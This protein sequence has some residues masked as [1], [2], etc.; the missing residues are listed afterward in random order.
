MYLFICG[1]SR[2]GS[3]FYLQLL[4]SHPNIWISPELVIRHPFKKDLYGALE[5]RLVNDARPDE[6][7]DFLYSLNLKGTYLA[8]LEKIGK[9]RLIHALE[10][11]LPLTA[12]KVIR[13]IIEE[14]GAG[15]SVKGAKFPVHYRYA[16]S[17][18]FWFDDVRI[19]FLTRDPRDIYCSDVENKARRFKAGMMR[20]LYRRLIRP[21]VLLLTLRD[22][23]K[24]LAMFRR[25]ERE[26]GAQKV[27]L[28]RYED[29]AGS[30]AGT[31][32]RIAD[33]VGYPETEFDADQIRHVDSSFPGNPGDTRWISVLSGAEKAVF[34]FFIGASLRRYGYD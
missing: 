10:G 18:F 5:R 25:L 4:N 20:E 7:V 1:I 29:I 12:E 6:V 27:L 8:T 13:A 17:L 33:F 23:S 34:R 19:L 21:A 30:R 14:A 3:K 9:A 16:P 32:R 2:T 28:C 11:A 15:Y 22:W 31:V 24:S 26:Y